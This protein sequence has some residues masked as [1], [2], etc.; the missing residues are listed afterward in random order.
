M[1][2]REQEKT[3][4]GLGWAR[5]ALAAVLSSPEQPVVQ[6]IGNQLS[7]VI[8]IGR[9]LAP[10]PFSGQLAK[11]QQRLDRF[12]AIAPENTEKATTHTENAEPVSFVLDKGNEKAENPVAQEMTQAVSSVAIADQTVAGVVSVPKPARTAKPKAEKTSRTAPKLSEKK[13]KP[14]AAK[15]TSEKKMVVASTEK[16]AST[17]TGSKTKSKKKTGL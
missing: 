4:F 11:L 15:K 12:L 13:A 6:Q 1:S 10:Q 17:N 7:R 2:T 9:I 8:A 14:I 3:S 16:K 5:A